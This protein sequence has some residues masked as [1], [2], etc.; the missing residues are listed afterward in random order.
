MQAADVSQCEVRKIRAPPEEK[1]VPRLVLPSRDA[2]RVVNTNP[3]FDHLVTRREGDGIV[4]INAHSALA[5]Q[6]ENGG[7]C[8]GRLKRV[9]CREGSEHPLRALT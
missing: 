6:P 1:P 7:E 3:V 8:R 5:C 2:Q 9:A 4:P